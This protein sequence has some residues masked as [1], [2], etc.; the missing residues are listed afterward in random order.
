MKEFLPSRYHEHH[1][2]C[3][4]KGAFLTVPLAAGPSGRR[5]ALLGASLAGFAGGA[6]LLRSAGLSG[7]LP[8]GHSGTDAEA[9]FERKLFVKED[10]V[11]ISAVD[12]DR[13][14]QVTVNSMQE[15]LYSSV[16]D[17]AC[18]DY[19]NNYYD[20]ATYTASSLDQCARRCSRSILLDEHR[21][22][23]YNPTKGSGNCNCLFDD[24]TTPQP[25][26]KKADAYAVEATDAEGEV[27]SSST[28]EARHANLKCYKT[29]SVNLGFVMDPYTAE[30]CTSSDKGTLDIFVFS[31]VT[32]AEKCARKCNRFKMMDTYLG[33][34][35]TKDDGKCVCLFVNG[36]VPTKRKLGASRGARS[37]E[38]SWQERFAAF[39]EPPKDAECY[40]KTSS[41]LSQS[42]APEEQIQPDPSNRVFINE[43]HI[44][45]INV[46]YPWIRV[47]GPKDT[48]AD[49]YA[50]Q[51]I[52]GRNGG[53]HEEIALSGTFSS[54]DNAEWGSVTASVQSG[55]TMNGKSGSDGL[56][57][58]GPGGTCVQFFSYAH[59]K[60]AVRSFKAT[61]GPCAG[62][63]S[64][65]INVM[66][67]RDVDPGV[68]IQLVGSGNRYDDFAFD[69]PFPKSTG[70]ANAGQTLNSP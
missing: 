30:D 18:L 54:D 32:T 3:D 31:G 25:V 21:G 45:N 24:G 59:V 68:S 29:E 9:E 10:D 53:L 19:L 5:K 58:V 60:S 43:F 34:T 44:R 57:L 4:R 20:H 27:Q 36:E 17:G 52:M 1:E 69:G 40:E 66:E 7:L 62:M 56:A 41:G 64:T 55:F 63:A 14:L 70:T 35:V 37:K 46:N 8:G 16:G 33:M 51:S 61:E 47:I 12:G 13:N 11:V 50:V 65:P 23:E 39:L 42:A 67:D 28:Q 49:G 15:G 6:A 38:L 48:S 2:L 22:F 26:W